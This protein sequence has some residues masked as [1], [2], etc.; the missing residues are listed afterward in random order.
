LSIS[1]EGSNVGFLLYRGN[2]AVLHSVL[3]L[4]Q[5]VR[6]ALATRERHMDYIVAGIAAAGLFGY[7]FYALLKPEKF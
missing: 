3:V 7:L 6:K 2:G 4:H 1:S 5:G